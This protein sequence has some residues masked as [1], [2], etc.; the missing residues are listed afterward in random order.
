MKRFEILK[1]RALAPN[2]NEYVV[3]APLVAKHCLAGQFVILIVDEGGERVPFT[4]CDYSRED[5]AVSI[6]VQEVGYTTA[7]L[8]MKNVGDTLAD[9]VGPLGNPTDL[10]EFKNVVLV[11]GGI[12][13]AVIYPQAKQLKSE[14]KAVDVIV[15]ARNESLLM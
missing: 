3:Y 8:A 12:G 11:G 9:F 2:V 15:G 6:L 7:K 1:K 14:G 10:K 4:I 5:G 13:S